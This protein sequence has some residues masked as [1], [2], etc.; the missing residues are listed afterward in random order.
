MH[1]ILKKNSGRA[2]GSTAVDGAVRGE[3][4]NFPVKTSRVDHA[5]GNTIIVRLVSSHFGDPLAEG[6]TL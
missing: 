6:S 1:G 5:G 4:M 2:R 3:E